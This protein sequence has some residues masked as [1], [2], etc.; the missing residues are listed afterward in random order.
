MM[1]K[2]TL[3]APAGV[4]GQIH[5]SQ[6]GKNYTIAEDGTVTVDS[7]DVRDLIGAGYQSLPHDGGPNT[8]TAAPISSQSVTAD[9][10]GATALDPDQREALRRETP[11]EA[12]QQSQDFGG[13]TPPHGRPLDIGADPA[14]RA[15]T[16]ADA[17]EVA[18]TAVAA[19]APLAAASPESDT[20][21]A[22]QPAGTAAQQAKALEEQGLA[23]PVET[24]DLRKD[25][26]HNA[27]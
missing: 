25:G 5:A 2:V 8:E 24:D 27:A 7:C 21:S 26:S 11:A 3:R 9:T 19:G 14:I 4:G 23:K 6:S 15:H 12:P 17:D 22:D 13:A 16:Q 1:P 20:G 18:R 10:Q